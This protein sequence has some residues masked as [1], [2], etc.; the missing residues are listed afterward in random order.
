[1][2]LELGI[3]MAMKLAFKNGET[4]RPHD[5]TALV[6]AGAPYNRAVSDLNGHDLKGYE[7]Q[8]ALISK[9]MLWLVTRKG[10]RAQFQPADI[11]R[12]LPL[13]QVA[14]ADHREG[15]KGGGVPWELMIRDGRRVA[16]QNGLKTMV[17]VPMGVKS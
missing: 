7:D 3:A 12:A 6:P 2:P 4:K 14:M 9:V 11:A 17:D 8:R 10:P 13:F 16:L 5:W 15:W 1:M